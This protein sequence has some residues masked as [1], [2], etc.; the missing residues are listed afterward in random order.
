MGTETEAWAQ[1]CVERTAGLILDGMPRALRPALEHTG[2]AHY[3]RAGYYAQAIGFEHPERGRLSLWLY[4]APPEHAYSA[5]VKSTTVAAGL[6]RTP[7]DL[8]PHDEARA[9]FAP[10]NPF[11]WRRL[12]AAAG[13][14]LYLV[15]DTM[16][17]K[18]AP[19]ETAER[20][21]PLVL[22]GLRQAGFF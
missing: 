6:K 17:R 2:D 8:L 15:A 16:S 10:E 14:Q 13:M 3:Q 21:A 18:G 9:W 1:A 12:D 22:D 5:G 7:Q 4:V 20:F 11:Q 19:E